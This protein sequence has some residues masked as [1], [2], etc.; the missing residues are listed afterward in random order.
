MRE[1]RRI[2]RKPRIF[3]SKRFEGK[4]AIVTGSGEGI[5][6]EILK[7]LLEEGSS[8]IANDIRSEVLDEFAKEYGSDKLIVSIGDV[9]DLT[10]IESLVGL[11]VA[12]FGKLDTVVANAGLTAW[13][14]FFEYTAEDFQN[15]VNLNLRGTFFLSQAASKEM[16]SQKTGGS[17]VF[18]SSVCAIRSHRNLAA[19]GMTKAGIMGLTQALVEEVSPYGIRVN[20]VSPGATVTPRNLADDPKYSEAWAGAVP[21]GKANMPADIASAVCY[22]ASDDASNI[23]GQTLVVDGGWTNI[24]PTPKVEDQY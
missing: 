24:S 13:G 23:T 19:Y 6:R 7:R 5:G 3:M 10:Y 18:I 1:Y 12:S 17:L 20:T 8:V 11:A 21:L 15:V 14:D 2:I 4:V 9:S 22:L 16:R